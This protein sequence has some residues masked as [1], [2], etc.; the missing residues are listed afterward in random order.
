MKKELNEQIKELVSP[1]VYKTVD[2]STDIYVLLGRIQDTMNRIERAGDNTKKI[3]DPNN[4]RLVIES[5]SDTIL[6]VGSQDVLSPQ[7]LETVKQLITLLEAIHY[8]ERKATIIDF[9]NSLKEQNDGEN[10]SK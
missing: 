6:N 5:R 3:L 9:N 10:A 4:W 7:I 2:E 1:S 8:S